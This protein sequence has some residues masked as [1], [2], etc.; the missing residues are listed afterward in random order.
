MRRTRIGLLTA[1]LL[2]AALTGVPSSYAGAPASSRA[3]LDAPV[4]TVLQAGPLK[5]S[6]WIPRTTSRAYKLTYVTTD[7]FGHK[8]PSTGTVFLPKGRAPRG[9]W[10]VVSWAHGTSGMGDSCAPSRVGPAMPKR[11][12]AYLGTWMRQGYAIVASDYAGLGTPGLHAYLHNR[13]T[14]HNVVDMVKAGRN[15]D[16]P[17]SEKLSNRWVVI[18]QSQGGGGAIATSSYAT[19]FGGKGLD[20]R[21]GVGTGTP[22]YIELLVSLPGPAVPPVDVSPALTSYLAYILAGMRHVHPELHINSVLTETG[23]KFVEMAEH[24]CVNEFEKAVEGTPIGDFFTRPLAS[25]PG[26]VQ[27]A[28]DYLGMPETSFE[29]P[30][31]MA[32]GAVDTDVP[33]ETTAAY[34]GVLT[35]N[36]ADVTF[37]TYPTDHN[38]TM[39]ASLVDSVPFVRALFRR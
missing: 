7:A 33:M 20:F 15:L 10:P 32:N 16:L 37:R 21:G 6:L 38:G 12:W 31:F 34:V 17:A 36:G 11:D 9:G 24:A 2:A 4:G 3:R 13:S 35:A 26:F 18:G 30:I 14:A 5:R 39:Q 28:R 27:A 25:L 8:A 19:E 29:K 22:A 1:A 23:K